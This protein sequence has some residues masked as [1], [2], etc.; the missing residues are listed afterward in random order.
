MNLVQTYS[1]NPGLC[2]IEFS[3]LWWVDI[4]V[5]LL[6]N[7]KQVPFPQMNSISE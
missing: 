7:I 1:M 4:V 6:V 3:V 5:C 2:L